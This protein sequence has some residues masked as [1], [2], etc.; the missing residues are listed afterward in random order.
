M[1]IVSKP[2]TFSPGATIVAAEHNDNFNTIY[3][4]FNGNISNGNISNSASI[5]YS[6]LALNN[7]IVNSDISSS[8]SISDSKLGQITT[9]SKVSGSAITNIDSIPDGWIDYSS[10]STVV[11]WSSFST[12]QIIYMK[13]GKIVFV[14]FVLIG[15]SNSTSCSF[16]LPYSASDATRFIIPF[17][18]NGA[19]VQYPG[20]G[21]IV[22]TDVTL[23]RDSREDGGSDAWTAGVARH[24]YGQFFY[25]TA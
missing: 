12:K 4:E 18:Y 9:A 17:T 16:T 7:S 3:N 13:I 11:G 19:Y 22:G 25:K 8:A 2:N 10:S 6:K 14:L 1:S 23:Y 5:S 15:D 24:I 21:R 20:M